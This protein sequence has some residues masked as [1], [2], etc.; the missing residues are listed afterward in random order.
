MV[1]TKELV[2]P[3]EILPSY[4]HKSNFRRAGRRFRRAAIKHGLV[5]DDR[6]L[7]LGCG[8]GRFAVAMAGHLSDRG[9][10]IGIDPA[11]RS[12]EICN[13]WIASKI[14][15]FQFVWADLYNARYNPTGQIRA[16]DYRFPCEDESID[17]A[18]SNS[19]FTHLLPDDTAHYLAELGRVLKPGGR[20]LNTIFVLND[21][22]HALL[23]DQDS[24]HGK[25]HHFEDVAWIKDRK[26]PER[27]IGFDE[28]FLRQAQEAA[29]LRV[30]EVV[31]GQWPG[32]DTPGIGF[33]KKDAIV[34][35]KD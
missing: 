20:A 15:G 13:E 17:F 18:F 24:G 25:L 14:G 3:R 28:A 27:W 19:L 22:T 4:A 11:K 31:F 29:G 30:E 6:I 2:P 10:Y 26:Q 9:S 16:T 8:A 7:E 35:V 34:A 5:P 21:E 33:G 23:K 32:R 12:I 1:R